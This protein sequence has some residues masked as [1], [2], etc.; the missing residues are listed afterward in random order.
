[1]G[2]IIGYERTGNLGIK[3]ILGANVKGGPDDPIVLVTTDANRL[4]HNDDYI[5]IRGT[6]PHGSTGFKDCDKDRLGD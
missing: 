3:V 2:N 4:G 5:A 1:M 6:I